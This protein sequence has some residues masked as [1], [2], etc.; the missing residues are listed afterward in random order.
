MYGSSSIEQG[1][2]NFLSFQAISCLFISLTTRKIKILKRWK[3]ATGGHYRFKHEYHKWKSY[4]VWFLRYETQ[5]TEFFLVL[6]H[7]LSFY[8]PPSPVTTQRTK[9][10]L[11]ISSFYT[12]VQ[13]ILII[14][15]TVPEIWHVT[16]V[17]VIFHFELFLL[18]FWA[19]FCLFTSPTAQKIK[20]SKKKKKKRKKKMEISSFY[21]CVP[22]IMI[23]WCT[24]LEILRA[25]DDRMD[26]RTDG[27]TTGKSDI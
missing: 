5:Q 8:T 1:R 26:E 2:Q 17:V 19:I 24:V 25:T 13:K 18:P 11:E 16:H 20:M 22:K 6:D 9:K 14:C 7:F 15:Y 4:D 10:H 23:S 12:S 21:T 3:K 27:Q